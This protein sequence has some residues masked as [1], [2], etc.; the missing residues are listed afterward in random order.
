VTRLSAR[1]TADTGAVCRA[2][3]AG[4]CLVLMVGAAG[5]GKST[6]ARQI[7]PG[8]GLVLSLDALRGTVSGD[9]CDQ[10]AT[11]DAAA[12]LHQLTRMRLRR[13]LTTIVDATN[14][15]AR[16][17]T[18]LA[19]I[20]RAA[21]VPCAAVAVVTPLPVCLARNEAR[22]GPAGGAQWGR[23]VPEPTVRTQHAE[24]MAALPLL[25]GEGFSRVILYDGAA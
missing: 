1:P 20:G 22:P 17:R 9:P 18:E 10:D 24:V 5:S 14:T 23:R 13:R 3:P 16:V 15:Q 6:L 7:C 12:V 4:P 8:G 25:R 19:E 11:G 21:G 2:L